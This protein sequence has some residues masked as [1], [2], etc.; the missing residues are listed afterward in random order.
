[1]W[2]KAFLV[3]TFTQE[4]TAGLEKTRKEDLQV[5]K[6]Q[7][8]SDLMYPQLWE[9]QGHIRHGSDNDKGL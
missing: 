6:P 4:Y 2:A 1:M 3:I 7:I 5:E 9:C 8:Q